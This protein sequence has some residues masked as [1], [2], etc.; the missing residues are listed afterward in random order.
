M[1]DSSLRRY[2][3]FFE[4]LSLDNLDRL[5][6]V[7]TDDIHFV[8]P[9]ND[10]IGVADVQAIFRHMFRSLDNPRFTVTH[11][12]MSG[13][14]EL[15]GLIRW[16][17]DSVLRGAPYRIVGMSEIGFSDDGRVNLHI[18]HWDAARQF[19][20]RLPVIGWLLRMIRSQLKV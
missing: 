4:H 20:E 17:L 8:D 10:V 14:R 19:Y 2:T 9:F 7:M 5:S 15:H 12:A 18:D 11:A 1:S 6:S 13:D 16:E 3:D